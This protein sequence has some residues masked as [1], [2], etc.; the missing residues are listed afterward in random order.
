MADPNSP[1]SGAVNTGGLHQLLY[2]IQLSENGD[3]GQANSIRTT[4]PQAESNEAE[5]SEEEFEDAVEALTVEPFQDRTNQPTMVT[6]RT[7][8]AATALPPDPLPTEENDTDSPNVSVDVQVESDDDSEITDPPARNLRSMETSRQKAF[9]DGYDSDGLMPPKNN[10][11]AEEEQLE[12][13]VPLGVTPPA[14]NDEAVCHDENEPVDDDVPP[15]E[16]I[17]ISADD[18][19]KLNVSQIKEELSIRN[20]SYPSRLK[21][22]EL[23]DRLT[24]AMHLPV[25]GN[26][27]KKGKK[28]AK[29]RKDRGVDDMAEFAPGA[30]WKVL[31][32]CEAPIEEPKNPSF[33]EKAHPPTVAAEDANKPQPTKH[34]FTHQFSREDFTGT[35]QVPVMNINGSVRKDRNGN[36]QYKTVPRTVGEPKESFLTQHNLTKDS[37]PAEFVEAFLPL[38]VNK[39]KNKTNIPYMSL[40]ECQQWTNMKALLA[41][42]GS[43]DCYKDFKPFTVKEIQQQL[44]LY[45]LNGISPSPTMDCKFDVDDEANFNHFVHSNMPNGLRRHRHFKAFFAVQ[46][47]RKAVPPRRNSPLFKLLPLLNWI[48]KVGRLSWDLS[49]HIS[50]DEQTIGFQGRHVD[51]RRITYKN[52]GDGFQADALCD[53]GFT[54]AIYFRNE[55]PPA[56]YIK[57]GLSPL[58]ARVMWLFDRLQELHTRVWMD[59]LYISAK[60]AKCAAVHDKRVL[61]SGVARKTGRGIPI[62]VLQD[63]VK[64]KNAQQKVRGTVKAAVLMGD[65]HVP[66]LVAVSVYDTKPVHFLSTVCECIEWVLKAKDVWNEAK[67]RMEKLEFL[68]LNVNDDYN[69][70]MNAVDI[71]DQLRGN[72]RF[73]YWLRNFKWWWA[74]LLWGVGVLMV[75]PYVM[76]SAVM[77]AAGVPNRNRLSHYQ[78]RL[79]VARVWID[80]HG[81]E[82]IRRWKEGRH[83]TTAEPE[84]CTPHRDRRKRSSPCQTTPLQPPTKGSIEAYGSAL[85]RQAYS[86]SNDDDEMSARKSPRLDDNALSFAGKLKGRLDFY[87]R[88]HLPMSRDA[89][90]KTKDTKCALHRWAVGRECNVRTHVM[91]CQD[92]LVPLCV[93]CYSVFHTIED[94]TLNK[95]SLKSK[96][97]EEF[98]AKKIQTKRQKK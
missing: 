82:V 36:I 86:S 38:K 59:N 32:P 4:H 70:D 83:P 81:D 24:L 75:N 39:Y 9:N 44:G 98:E 93:D 87:G 3:G 41:N 31:S 89:A 27:P 63:E 47:P 92:C 69:K 78:F 18:I 12:E 10:T 50:V 56:K 84:A 77:D 23:R 65:K 68:R 85:K 66:N 49:M 54:Y 16:P 51:K 57:Q 30:Y 60:F 71:A 33:G 25:V 26:R 2:G 55:K 96:M 1:H 64:D 79:A 52:E 7:R 94:L 80:L 29:K 28:M 90:G 20:V 97:M 35:K 19:M 34:N 11:E 73:D 76:Y 43:E 95:A 15:N 42:A 91:I 17:S 62:S 37:H 13:E 46:D 40:T 6:T 14:D 5:S 48:N 21:K 67:Q 58:H 61:I 74:I 72:Y 45:I 8:K 22:P 53:R 88:R